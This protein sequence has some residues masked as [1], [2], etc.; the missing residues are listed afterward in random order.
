MS[1]VGAV[2]AS[3]K[4][5]FVLALIGLYLV[6]QV[7]LTLAAPGKIAPF[8][9]DRERVNVRATLPFPAERFHVL[10]FQGYG[11]VS[12]TTGNTVEIRGVRRGDLRAIA[13]HYWVRRVEPLPEGG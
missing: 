1:L 12:G 7:W 4:G 2:L 10:V 5:R 8:A 9:G 11:R 13:R 3:N 6:W